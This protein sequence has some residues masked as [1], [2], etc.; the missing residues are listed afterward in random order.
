MTDSSTG[1][2]WKSHRKMIVP[3][4]HTSILKSFIPVFNKRSRH[5][6]DKLRKELGREFDVHDYMSTVTV[7]ILLETAMGIQRGKEDGAGYDYAM[8][9]MK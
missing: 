4:F 1:E 5:I 7:D 6:V 8:A 2:K 3:T 9:V